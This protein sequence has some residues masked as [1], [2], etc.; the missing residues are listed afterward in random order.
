M[1]HSNR[2]IVRI[3]YDVL[4]LFIASPLSLIH[5]S[6]NPI[7][8]FLFWELCGLSPNFHIHVPVSDLHIPRI[9][10]HISC[11]RIGRSIVGI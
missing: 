3:Q 4:F 1:E 10:P 6:E 5:C 2:S 9:G 7:Y 8:A 11:S